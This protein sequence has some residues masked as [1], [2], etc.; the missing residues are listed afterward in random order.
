ALRRATNFI[1][2]RRTRVGPSGAPGARV[3]GAATEASPT[4]YGSA[5]GSRD[6]RGRA[7][8]T[9]YATCR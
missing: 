5:R 6:A 3:P 8:N 1:S 7:R 2:T 9:K 4:R